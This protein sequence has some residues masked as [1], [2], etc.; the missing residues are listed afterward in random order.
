MKL[1]ENK[2]MSLI[3]FTIILA[4]LLVAA[5]G[6]IVYLL[7]N[8]KVVEKTPTGQQNNVVNNESVENNSNN[9]IDKEDETDST[10]INVYGVGN[11]FKNIEDVAKLAWDSF[12]DTEMKVLEYDLDNDGKKEKIS[13][14]YKENDEDERSYIVI[15]NKEFKIG[16]YPISNIYIVD[17]DKNDKTIEIIALQQGD[18]GALACDIGIYVNGNY[19]KIKDFEIFGESLLINESGKIIFKWIGYCDSIL[20]EEYYV[21]NNKTIKTETPNLDSIAIKEFIVEKSGDFGPYYTYNKNVHEVCTKAMNSNYNLEKCG[22]Y[23]FKENTKIQI[24]DFNTGYGNDIIEAKLQ[25]GK[26]I[27]IFGHAGFLA[28]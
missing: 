10:D 18:S 15:N 7:N 27:Y 16:Y 12:K 22:I 26:I 5:C 20:T 21:Y 9:V 8:P 25:N 23:T 4:V 11:D 3:V 6:V 24:I 17:L 14:E 1:K 19:E 2:G 28:G 13:T